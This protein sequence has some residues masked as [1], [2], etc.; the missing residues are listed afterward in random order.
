MSSIDEQYSLILINI[1]IFKFDIKSL[2][3]GS[4]LHTHWIKYGSYNT[5]TSDKN[6]AENSYY[7]RIHTT[8]TSGNK[9]LVGSFRTS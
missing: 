8:L 9:T 2:K 4:R 6:F 5:R 1:I 7:I 3:L